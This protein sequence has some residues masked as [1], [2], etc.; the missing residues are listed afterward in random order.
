MRATQ[1][2][3]ERKAETAARARP[4][5]RPAA[6]GAAPCAPG[7]VA[8][9][10]RGDVCVVRCG[11]VP[12]ERLAEE[13]DAVLAACARE[14]GQ[15]VVVD[16]DPWRPL[17]E[18]GVAALRRARDRL[19][20]EGRELV[21]AVEE[22]E[23]RAELAA[24]GL[25][26]RRPAVPETVYRGE[27]AVRL[28]ARPRWEHEFTFPARADALP[29]ARRRVLAYAEV[30]GLSGAALFELGVAVSEALTN[31]VVHGS[32]HG[33]DDDVRVRF[34][35]FEDEV[36]VEVIDSGGGIAASPLCAPPTGATTGRGL[37]FIRALTDAVQFSCGPLG[38]HVLLVKHRP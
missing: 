28:P 9:E 2:A 5:R 4:G 21:F 29:A 15:A 37:H 11:G 16:L 13:I 23:A 25:V 26:R 17:G 19:A 34:F 3:E 35:C 22:D 18:A 38:T 1:V 6:A 33:G 27:G 7:H 32:P 36:A 12:G 24:A 14:G 30:A 20:G 8:V 10:R 31:A